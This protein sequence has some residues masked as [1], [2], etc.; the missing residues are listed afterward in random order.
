MTVLSD[1]IARMVDGGLDEAEAM[2]IAAELFAAGA[3]CQAER[4]SK[5]ALRTRKWRG[6]NRHQGVTCDTQ[7]AMSES[8]T[9]R[10]PPSQSVTSNNTPLSSS[11]TNLR[12]RGERLSPDWSPTDADRAFARDLGWSNSQ[13]DSEA[14]NFRDY[15]IAKPGAGGCKLDWP[16]TWRKWVRSS[17]VKP[18]GAAA[19][20]VS[21]RQPPEQAVAHFARFGSWSKYSPF[22]DISQVPIELLTKCGLS[23]SGHKLSSA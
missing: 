15:W 3:A 5:G 2:Q 7:S 19:F 11:K 12:K 8:V 18:A 21:E 22:T 16:A 23:P 1:Y 20:V 6:K 9:E 4:P 10:H 14:A 17:K 13:I